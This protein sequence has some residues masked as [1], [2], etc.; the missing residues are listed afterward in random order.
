MPAF[1]P[2]QLPLC[3][4]PT[5]GL[6]FHMFSHYTGAGSMF[7]SFFSQKNQ[8]EKNADTHVEYCINIYCKIK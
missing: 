4:L 8:E 6:N 3:L 1:F 2:L 7:S 5:A